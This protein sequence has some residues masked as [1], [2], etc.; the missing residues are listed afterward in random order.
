MKSSLPGYEAKGRMKPVSCRLPVKRRIRCSIVFVLLAIEL[1]PAVSQSRPNLK[2]PL[3]RAVEA[4]GMTVADMD[5]SIAFYSNVLSFTKVSES[6]QDS[7]DYQ[8]LENVPEAKARVVRL[9]LGNGVIELTQYS[10]PRGKPIPADSASNDLWFQHLAIVVSNMQK[11]YERLRQ[12]AVQHISDRPQRLPRW[13]KQAA[14]IEA[15]YFKDPDGH[16]LELIYF[17]E[18][19]GDPRW[20]LQLDDELFLGVDHTAIAAS[21]TDVSMKFYRLLGFQE[22]GHSLNYGTEQD[23]LSGVVGARVRITSLRANSGPGIELLEYQHPRT[24]R[25][26]Q[27][28]ERANDLIHHQTTLVVSRL[29]VAVKALCASF[30]SFV[31]SGTNCDQPSTWESRGR[32]LVRDPDRHVLELVQE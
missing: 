3:V 29:D 14:D 28:D 31:T 21:N 6:N 19:K 4:V 10:T 2:Q 1:S 9:R 25:P 8:Q 23:H 7:A 13:N 17:P 15:F 32:V 26:M 22:R 24:G 30:V 18:G 11:A 20:H 27:A 16:P 12:N 5:R